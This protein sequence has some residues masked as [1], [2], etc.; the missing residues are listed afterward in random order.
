MKRT[1]NK[2]RLAIAKRNASIAPTGISEIAIFPKT[3]PKPHNVPAPVSASKAAPFERRFILRR[4]RI[5]QHARENR[6]DSVR[7]AGNTAHASRCRRQTIVQ[8][9]DLPEAR[10]RERQLESGDLH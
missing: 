6:A 4:P 1:G 9:A 7:R 8:R 2:T 10:A 5:V 3:N